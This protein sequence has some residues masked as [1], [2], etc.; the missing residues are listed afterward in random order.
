[1]LCAWSRITSYNVCY[2]KLLRVARAIHKRTSR[3]E[4]VYLDLRPVV[5]NGQ[6]DK[7]PQAFEAGRAAGFD[8]ACEPL[9]VIPAVV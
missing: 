4:T 8:P 3:G 1:M 9:P 7:F 5:A 6:A 2:T